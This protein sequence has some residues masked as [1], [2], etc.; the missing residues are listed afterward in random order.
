[1]D[2]VQ[3]PSSNN[4]WEEFVVDLEFDEIMASVAHAK[5]WKGISVEHWS[6]AWRIDMETSQ[7]KINVITQRLVSTD[8]PKLNR[9]FGTGDMMLRYKSTRIVF[10]M[11]N[12]FATNKESHMR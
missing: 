7:N 6:N 10:F 3:D 2:N 1:M 9:N 8:N 4:E 5:P 11:D 12:L